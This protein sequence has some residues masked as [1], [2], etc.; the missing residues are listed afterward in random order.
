[1]CDWGSGTMCVEIC[2]IRIFTCTN[3]HGGK[4]CGCK[5]VWRSTTV[6]VGC[7]GTAECF[8]VVLMNEGEEFFAKV[9]VIGF[10]VHRG[11]INGKTIVRRFFLIFL[12][13][14]ERCVVQRFKAVI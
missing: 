8:A 3:Q 1:M 7:D 14:L 13:I 9:D 11:G 2:D 10:L 12:M 6:G 4:Q 5:S